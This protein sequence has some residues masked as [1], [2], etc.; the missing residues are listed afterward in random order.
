MES[1]VV[2]SKVMI[3]LPCLNLTQQIK[4]ELLE[5]LI[6]FV[7]RRRIIYVGLIVPYPAEVGLMCISKHVFL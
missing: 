6:F 4:H 2:L 7:T 1:F 3:F 5:L